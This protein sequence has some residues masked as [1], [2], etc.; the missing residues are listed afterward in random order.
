MELVKN[1]WS[2]SN[3]EYKRLQELD[4]ADL[5]AII[6]SFKLGTGTLSRKKL[7][8]QLYDSIAIK[9]KPKKVQRKRASKGSESD[10]TER[11]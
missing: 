9:R 1:R 8:K 10:N 11:Q 4:K 6:K 3:K 7:E 5:M 2:V